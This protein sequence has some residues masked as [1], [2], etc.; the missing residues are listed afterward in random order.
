M[1]ENFFG[2]ENP[3]AVKKQFALDASP[4]PFVSM[5]REGN[6]T[7]IWTNSKGYPY[8]ID[9]ILFYFKEL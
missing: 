5:C 3:I 7:T 6:H 1:Y 8:E 4:S 2:V 9:N